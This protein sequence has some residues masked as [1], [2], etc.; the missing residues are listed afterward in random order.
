MKIDKVTQADF[1]EW[2][3]LALQ[4]WPDYSVAE[5]QESL[6]LIFHSPREAAFLVRD[7]DG[8]SIGFMNLS[9]RSDYVPDATQSPVAYI[10]G[11][12]VKDDYRK[13]VP[14]VQH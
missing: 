9:L 2:L 4:L 12:Y 7:Q 13:Q 5:M 3:D 10:E 8:R 6:T 1:Q 14:I 11:L